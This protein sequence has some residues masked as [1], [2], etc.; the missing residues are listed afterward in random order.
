M[1][2]TI[3]F[4]GLG[5]MGL[6]MA[7]NVLK[8][9]YK[10][11]GNDLRQP[12]LS[13]LPNKDQFQFIQSAAELAK[14]VDILILML[15][16]SK[17][18]DDTLWNKG[19]AAALRKGATIVDMS[20]SHPVNSRDNEVKLKDLGLKFIDAPVSGG[21]KKAIDGSLSIIIGGDLSTYEAVKSLLMTMG[22]T[23]VHVGPAGAGHAIKA[24]NNYVSAAGLIAASEALV[25]AGQF[26]IDP[27]VVNQV[28]NAS[29]GKNNSTENKVEQYMLNGAFNSGFSLA[30]MRKDVETALSFMNLVGKDA[31]LAKECV[32]VC[33][34]AEQALPEKADHTAVYQYVK[35][36][37]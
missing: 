33:R 2:A 3:G 9:G 20:S 6:P 17:I 16:D 35:S 34:A 10:V 23:L 25:A 1:I 21:V 28:L 32:S 5:Q 30:L 37:S 29:T 7:A 26:G 15:P 24:L 4:I 27:H 11:L 22:K 18:V 14:Q 31:Q 19:V 13:T 36:H 8:A 12:E